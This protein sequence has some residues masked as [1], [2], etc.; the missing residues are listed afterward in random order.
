MLFRLHNKR[1]ASA[2]VIDFLKQM[3]TLIIANILL[4]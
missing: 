4:R 3:L 1:T 2:E